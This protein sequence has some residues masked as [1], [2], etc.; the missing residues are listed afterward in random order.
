MEIAK[1]LYSLDVNIHAC[2][3][4]AFRWSCCIGH[5]EIAKWLYSLGADIHINNDDD[6]FIVS[7]ANGHME[8]V[9]WLCSVCDNYD[10]KVHNLEIM[11]I[12][13]TKKK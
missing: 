12:I 2:Y 11:P 9:K 5:M 1:W 7:C 3:K 8:I 10:Y 13:I 6:A 4:C